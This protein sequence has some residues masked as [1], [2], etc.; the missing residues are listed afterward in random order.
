MTH[1]LIMVIGS[2]QHQLGVML[3]LISEFLIHG[4]N[5]KSL[6]LNA[7]ILKNGFQS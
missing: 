7:F 2:G 4:Y 1:P 6:I 5:K 3:N